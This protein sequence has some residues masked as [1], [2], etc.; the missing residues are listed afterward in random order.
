MIGQVASPR[1]EEP[2]EPLYVN[3]KQYH[4][5]LKRRA[6]RAN[7]EAQNR[8]MQRGRKFMHESRH[9]HAMRRPRGPGGRFLTA[10]EIAALEGRDTKSNSSGKGSGAAQDNNNNAIDDNNN[11]A[12]TKNNNSNSSNHTRSLNNSH[13]SNSNEPGNHQTYNNNNSSESG[14]GNS[15]IRYATGP[16][17]SNRQTGSS[18]PAGEGH[19][20]AM[21]QDGIQITHSFHP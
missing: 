17:S 2:E 8:L 7:L 15:D 5:I 14:H 9:L 20:P 21:R 4:R 11:T 12:N 13:N 19:R 6:A 16:T 10:A 18:E 3:A 1:I